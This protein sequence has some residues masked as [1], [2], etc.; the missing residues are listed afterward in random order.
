MI[1][2]KIKIKII[3]IFLLTILLFEC[4]MMV[5]CDFSMLSP[6]TTNMPHSS[7]TITEDGDN[8]IPPYG[9]E[10]GE[11][12][13]DYWQN[14]THYGLVVE[15]GVITL[16]GRPY[17]AAG[18]NCYNLFNQCFYNVSTDKAKESLVVLKEYDIKVVRFN[19]GGYGYSDISYYENNREQYLQKLR[20]IADY[21][22]ELEIG[23]IPSFFWLYHAV[24]DYFD[25]PIKAWGR[26]D[27][28]TIA[29]MKQYTTD[30][31]EALKDSKALFAWEFGN[32]HN[33]S[34]N[35]PNAAEHTPT[36]PI[37]SSRTE[38]SEDDYLSAKDIS[39]AMTVFA[40]TIRAIDDSGRM[41]TSGN[42]SQRPSQ[43]HQLYY[44][45]WVNDT[46]E[47]YTI[48]TEL[49]NPGKIDCVSE[50]TYFTEHSSFGEELTL[51]EYLSE[52]REI[53]KSLGKAYF[54]GEWG[55]G[56]QS[57]EYCRDVAD[58]I[59]AA[60]VQLSLLWNFNLEENSVEHSFSANSDKGEEMLAII[61]EMNSKYN[62][63]YTMG[64]EAYE[65]TVYL[66]GNANKQSAG[67]C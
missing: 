44:N 25:E 41:I 6:N 8:K 62:R 49:L 27:S 34:C 38:R 43:Y 16:N 18:V 30:I 4:I 13:L 58:Q 35:L 50:H 22:E 29:F 5:S 63:M 40:E 37:G 48:V 23:L 14:T 15:D 32:E 46:K 53:A 39:Y 9:D 31:V 55:G 17:Y 57:V 28:K 45:S 64:W 26:S 52:A 24:P 7:S 1:K 33:L 11:E 19:C 2:T 36:L 67:A 56:S 10:N 20:E 12:I 60:G 47:E 59:V 65:E 61:G 66:C 54:V 42:A 21:A 51:E 3:S